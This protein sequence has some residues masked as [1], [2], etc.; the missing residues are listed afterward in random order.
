MNLGTEQLTFNLM[1]NSRNREEMTEAE[2]EMFRIKDFNVLDPLHRTIK[3]S[4][5]INGVQEMTIEGMATQ[6]GAITDRP[7][8]IEDHK[9]AI[10]TRAV[11]P[12]RT[13][14]TIVEMQGGKAKIQEEDPKMTV[15]TI[16]ASIVEIIKGTDVTTGDIS[17]DINQ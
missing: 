12:V 17:E 11:S 14:I 7:R 10:R 1:D 9:D 8:V 2:M 16:K 15:I 13:H 5:K 4:N 6:I 3:I